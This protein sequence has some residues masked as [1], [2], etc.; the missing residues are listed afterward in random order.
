MRRITRVVVAERELRAG[1]VGRGEDRK[2]WW[3]TREAKVIVRDP[4][5]VVCVWPVGS[6]PS[7]LGEYRHPIWG[8]SLMPSLSWCFVVGLSNKVWNI[9]Y[10]QGGSVSRSIPDNLTRIQPSGQSSVL[11]LL[12]FV[13]WIHNR[14][15]LES[16]ET[17]SSESSSL[18]EQMQEKHRFCRGSVTPP[19]VQ[20]STALI[21]R[22]LAIGYVLVS[23]FSFHLTV[24]PGS[25]S[26]CYHRGWAG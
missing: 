17:S 8:V 20:R 16:P 13:L 15:S 18:E 5:E 10:Q 7:G 3:Q 22:D 1:Q 4:V 11:S 12:S 26:R 6:Y 14:F 9:C 2:G 19:T 21:H 24:S 23:G 25:T